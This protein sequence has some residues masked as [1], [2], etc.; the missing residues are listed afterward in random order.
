MERFI[1]RRMNTQCLLGAID[2]ANAAVELG[3]LNHNPA[4]KGIA[5]EDIVD[6]P[7]L[8]ISDQFD[9]YGRLC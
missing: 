2:V 9:S 7:D 4:A 6:L 5:R 8:P 3:N 1:G